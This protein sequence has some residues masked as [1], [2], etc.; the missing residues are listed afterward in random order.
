M[1]PDRMSDHFAQL[2]MTAGEAAS[3]AS[4]V[5]QVSNGFRA[6]VGA[7]PEWRWFVPGRIEV[8]GKHTDYA[9]GRSLLAAVPRGIAVVASPR[10]DQIVRVVDVR[11]GTAVEIDADD[12]TTTRRGFANYIRVVARRL[13]ENFPGARLGADIGICSDL[14]RAAGVSSSSALVVGV[15][16][17][18]AR[19]AELAARPEWQQHIG[20][21]RD[22]AWYLGCVENGL[23]FPGLPGAAGV[24]T[25]GGSED[26][27]AIMACRT[28]HLSHYQFVPVRHLADVPMPAGWTFVVAS[29]GIQADKAG[30][31]LER[32]NRAANGTRALLD[33]WNARAAQPARSLGA[34]L[35]GEHGAERM[36]SCLGPSRDGAFTTEDLYRRLMHFMREDHRVALAAHAFATADSHTV[37]ALSAA[38]QRDADE[39]LGNQIPETNAL[40]GAARQAGALA[41][42]SFGAGFGGSV[43]ALVARAEVAA[44]SKQ[45]VRAYQRQRP[46]IAEVECFE[47]HPGPPLTELQ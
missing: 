34:A 26:H 21:V 18:L 29:S 16:S 41:A 46:E 22:L 13:A 11:Y 6:A 8:F 36:R 33:L 10:P 2:G 45:W 31:V 44:F 17:A 23:D 1:T 3:R 32:Y 14:P 47:A 12:A 28:G 25:H 37:G 7:D 4:L 19:R 40:V 39:L 15:A 24:G 9:G 20:S 35:S 27:T 42:S 38:S 30:S 43:W 5:Q